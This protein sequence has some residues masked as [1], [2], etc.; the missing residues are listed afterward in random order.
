MK[1]LRY[2][3]AIPLVLF[4]ATITTAAQCGREEPAP[5]GT[6]VKITDFIYPLD[7]SIHEGQMMSLRA[8]IK[9][10]SIARD[11]TLYF[12]VFGPTEYEHTESFFMNADEQTY[13]TYDTPPIDWQGYSDGS[14]RVSAYIYATEGG[15]P[16]DS[17]VGYTIVDPVP[18]SQ[19]ITQAPSSTTPSYTHTTQT[20]LTII[21]PTVIT[22]T[23]TTT[24]SATRPIPNIAGQWQWNLTV[25]VAKGVCAGEEGVQPPCTVQITQNGNDVTISGFL[26]SN[27]STSLS[28]E[29]TF[30]NA[31]DKWIIKFSGRY[32][33]D[34]GTTQSN[35]TLVLD[36]TFDK[37]T[38]DE[39]WD[40]IGG[41][42]SCT[43]SKSTVVANKLP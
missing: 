28:G 9:N 15:A 12:H 3:Y 27:P 25:T 34:Q 7:H 29:I 13:K 40:W 39:E 20:V 23:S 37:M 5:P 21:P 33:E 36:N 6:I 2:L 8:E 31:A 18:E 14:F 22:G 38:G 11:Y 41:G 26:A 42:Q 43:G 35:Y 32:S 24:T 16:N 30:D 1:S 10:G 17:A 4:L 19:A